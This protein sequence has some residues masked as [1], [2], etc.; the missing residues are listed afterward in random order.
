MLIVSKGFFIFKG[1]DFATKLF[2]GRLLAA[3]SNT[4]FGQVIRRQF[5]FD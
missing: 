5:N 2:Y 4:T 1:M 3:V